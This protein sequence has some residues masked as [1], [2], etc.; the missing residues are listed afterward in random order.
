[1]GDLITQKIC[2]KCKESKPF[3]EFT[4]SK[5]GLLGLHNFCRECL[6]KYNKEIYQRDK[7][8]IKEKVKEWNAEHVENTKIYKAKSYYKKRGKRMPKRAKPNHIPD[9]KPLPPEL[10][11]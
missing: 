2:G 6:S 1:M 7:E 9:A 3:K 5:N 11:F 4:K 10:D 8:K